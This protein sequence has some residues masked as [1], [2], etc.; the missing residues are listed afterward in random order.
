MIHGQRLSWVSSIRT[1]LLKT[2][3]ASS[4][5]FEILW[6]DLESALQLSSKVCGCYLV[7]FLNWTPIF[8]SCLVT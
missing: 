6:F 4:S 7:S 8:D 2:V 1:I 3:A 5:D